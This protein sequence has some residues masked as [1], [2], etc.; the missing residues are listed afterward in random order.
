M[1][2]ARDKDGGL[3][4]P[5]QALNWNLSNVNRKPGRPRKNCQDIVFFDTLC[6]FLFPFFFKFLVFEAAKNIY[7][8]KDVYYPNGFKGHRIDVA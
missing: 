3:Q 5:N 7:A 8:N 2:R 4:I 1:A 6:V